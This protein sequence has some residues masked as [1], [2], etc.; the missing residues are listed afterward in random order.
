MRSCITVARPLAVAGL[1]VATLILSA[2]AQ[3]PSPL[4]HV[5]L[6]P[7][8]APP[9]KNEEL[10]S[11]QLGIT[12]DSSRRYVVQASIEAVVAFYQH[13]LA[14]REVS[15]PEFE[16]ALERADTEPLAAV[17]TLTGHEFTSPAV[18]ALKDAVTSRPPIG[19][20]DGST[21]RGSCGPDVRLQ[22]TS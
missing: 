9:P 5:P 10:P 17:F 3:A 1:S 18:A 21:G 6:Y 7:G 16:A 8:A 15:A 4:E 2:R 11:P 14:A 13:R 20:D 12:L 19:R 22:G